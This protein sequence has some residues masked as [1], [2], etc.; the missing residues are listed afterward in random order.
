LASHPPDLPGMSSKNQEEQG[1]GP[2]KLEVI[3][4]VEARAYYL[5]P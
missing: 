3:T 1:D 5:I 2:P 4:T